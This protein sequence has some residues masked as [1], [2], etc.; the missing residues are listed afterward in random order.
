MGKTHT[1][2]KSKAAAGTKGAQSA[3]SERSGEPE[4]VRYIVNESGEREAV[5]LPVQLYE[6]LLSELEDLQDI[7]DADAAMKED[8]W[9]AWEEVKKELDVQSSNR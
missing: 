2:K 6:K 5:V 9:V 7:R 3:A 1:E 8:D 4:G